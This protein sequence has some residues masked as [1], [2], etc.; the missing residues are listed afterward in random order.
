MKSLAERTAFRAKQKADEKKE[1]D[2]SPTIV[3]GG[4]KEGRIEQSMREQKNAELTGTGGPSSATGEGEE[5]D[6]A[7]WIDD[8]VENIANSF[9]ELSDDELLAI[10]KAENAGKKRNGVADAISKEKKRRE[11]AGSKWGAGK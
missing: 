10:E 6:A 11:N 8:S 3:T 4:D 7:A 1:R 2:T 9:S 5:F